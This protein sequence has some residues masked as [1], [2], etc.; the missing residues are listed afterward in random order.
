M[1]LDVNN[2]LAKNSQKLYTK[3]WSN[4]TQFLRTHFSIAPLHCT[5]FEVQHYIT[6]LSHFQHLSIS[7]IRGHLSAISYH[8]QLK[9]NYDPTKSFAIS[10]LLKT[11]SKKS[12]PKITRKPIDHTILSKLIISLNN[13][14]LPTYYKLSY[15]NIFSFMYH[16]ALRVSEVSRTSSPQHDLLY[17][18]VQF[19][20]RTSILKITFIS[21]KHSHNEF[22]TIVTLCDSTLTH[23]ILQYLHLRGAKQ[24]YFFC[25][26]DATPF[27][28]IEIVNTLKHHLSTSN[29]NSDLY[30]SHSFRIGKATD[31]ALEGRSEIEIKQ[32]GRWKSNAYKSYLKPQ[33]VY[34]NNGAHK[35]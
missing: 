23:S 29:Y 22:P 17:K 7:S 3:Y 15:V 1:E 14:P 19:E 33:Q 11:Y 13:S 26:P 21:Y 12:I 8:I 4:F 10:R 35:V 28:R 34:S 20:K 5:P 31:M 30:N 16:A 2:S 6:Y 24:G 18:C 25:H 27:T 9:T 32:L